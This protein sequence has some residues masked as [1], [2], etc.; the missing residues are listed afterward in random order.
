[1][2]EPIE[3]LPDA[4]KIEPVISDNWDY[5]ESVKKVRESFISWTT[6]SESLIRELYIAKMAITDWGRRTCGATK[7]GKTSWGKY[8]S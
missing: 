8:V 4:V 6:I 5:D 1:M 3:L 2:S 7:K